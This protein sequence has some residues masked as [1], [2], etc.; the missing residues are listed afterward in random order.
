MNI[1]SMLRDL[2][3]ARPARRAAA[4]A[5]GLCLAGGCAV[6]QEAGDEAVEEGLAPITSLRL[7]NGAE[8][9]FYEP[10]E[11][12]VLTFTT[13][14]VPGAAEELPPVALYEALSGQAA[15]QVLIDAPRPRAAPHLDGGR[16]RR[17]DA[18]VAAGRPRERARGR[19]AGPERDQLPDVLLQQCRPRL[20]LLLDRQLRRPHHGDLERQLAPR[21]R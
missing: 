20:R 19:R 13:G 17:G 11:G 3:M 10:E 1:L 18:A 2:S 9:R 21:T 14:E 5:L 4:L 16:P 12:L 15:P 6:E 7:S 8:V